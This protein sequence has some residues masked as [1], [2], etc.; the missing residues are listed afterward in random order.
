MKEKNTLWTKDFILI[1]VGTVLSAIGGESINLPLSLMVFD[2]TQSTFLSALLLI[3]SMLPDTVLSVFIAPI[4]DSSSK[5]K[6]VVALDF[7]LACVLLVFGIII[8]LSE[9]NYFLYLCFAFLTGTISVFYRLAFGAWYPDLIK[10][11]FEQQGFAVSTT[12]YPMVMLLTSPIAAALYMHISMSA[13]LYIVAALLFLSA[14][15]ELFITADVPKASEK[16]QESEFK[17][18]IMEIKAGFRF[19]KEEIG[20]K[21]IYI[22]RSLSNGTAYGNEL[23]IQAL[24]QSSPVLTPLMFS[25]L[26]SA[27][28]AGRMI[29]GIFQYRIVVPAEKRFKTV[30]NIYIFHYLL[31]MVLLFSSYPLMI[32]NR[33]LIGSSGAVSST[34]TE[35][36]IQSY[37]PKE[38]RARVNAIFMVFISMAMIGFQF[39][40][41]LLGEYISY[42]RVVILMSV[43]GFLFIYWLILRPADINR[44]VYEA[45]RDKNLPR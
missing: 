33:F 2:R 34:T 35:T 20:I 7:L 21:N 8:G 26:K 6:F 37:L 11:G 18:Y 29:G 10:V 24:F 14:F 40:V 41:G 32:V 43:F 15:L 9:F 30:V 23:M 19:M 25:F 5:K 42:R 22:F 38:M 27:E 28:T 39:L 4:I 16:D 13:I 1:T 3:A 44:K 12:I 36:A 45:V 17:R 31:D